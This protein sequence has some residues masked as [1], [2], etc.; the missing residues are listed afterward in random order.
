MSEKEIEQTLIKGVELKESAKFAESDAEFTT[1][2]IKSEKIGYH[3]GFLHGL[4]NK[5]TIWKI[6]SRQ[7]QSRNFAQL[8]RW[9]FLQAVEYAQ[10]N[11]LAEEEKI[12]AK[13]LLGQ[14]EVELG[15]YQKAVDLYQESFDF[16][17][18]H[19]RSQ[20]HTGDVQRH[21]GTALAK[22][23]KIKEG[24]ENISQALEKIRQLDDKDEFA[25][26]VWETGALL[27]L[28]EIYQDTDKE[29][30]KSLTKEA[31]EIAKKHNLTIRKQEA[32]RLLNSLS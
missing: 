13:F 8:A 7:E 28:A 1:A 17:S 27:S 2:I 18:Q 22:S 25:N 26:R 19:P 9:C 5:G 11:N 23:G 31:W 15:H 16:Y 32:E 29:K 4:F 6:L 14:A 10:N 12:H 30:A 3:H 20:A 21:L 24:V